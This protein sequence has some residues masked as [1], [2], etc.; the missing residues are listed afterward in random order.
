MYPSSDKYDVVII[1]S[2]LGGLLCGY[3]LSKNGYKVAIFEKN[4][5][6]GGCLQTFKRKGVKF[7]TGMH[8]VG[9]LE[10][11]QMLNKVWKYLNLFDD[12][13]LSKL[14]PT[15]FDVISIAGE[16]YRFASGFENY[17]K[18]L[19]ERFP[20]EK[21]SIEKYVDAIRTI[22]KS[23]PLY[24]LQ[25]P[26][27][28]LY[29][30]SDYFKKSVNEFIGEIVS[31]VELQ[32]VLIGNLPLY[33]GEKNR[34]PIYV[35]ALIQ[36]FYI[37]SSYRIIGGGDAVS[38]S[39]SKSIT[40]MGGQIFANAEVVHIN[41]DEEKAV[42]V[43]LKNGEVVE[44]H[45]FI[46]NIHPQST[47]DKI[48]SKLIRKAYRDRV[49]GLENTVSNFAVYILFKKDTVPY[50]NYNYYHF[51]DT[52]VWKSKEF[53]IDNIEKS[54]FYIH[55]CDEENQ[56]YARAA[57]I[58]CYM[59]YSD[60]AKWAGTKLGNRGKDYEEFKEKIAKR[61]LEKLELAFPNT[62]NNI[63][64]YYTSTPLTYS[65]YTATKE[66]SMYGVLRD[67]NFPSSTMVSQRTKIPNMFLTGQNINSHGVL[68]VT[69]GALI[70]CA[71]FV[72][73]NKIIDDINGAK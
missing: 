29:I 16:R 13:K 54:Y 15:G 10:E 28:N 26:H 59:K 5:Q 27:D 30:E 64:A 47:L 65:D 36:N 1:G 43:T 69:I 71:E 6:I 48:S 12:V 51:D 45:K 7:D 52:D 9:S 11:G 35:H 73:I 57:S 53:N 3:I 60:V 50:N 40:Q 23:S 38:S 19:C 55:Q 25:R 70:T 22:G 4:A 63:E 34:T 49:S 67:V 33:A 58:I 56:K 62:I 42:S 14:D 44:A 72:G 46:S 2:G 8:Y 20:K 24:N 39:L 61:L 66:G 37:Q 18:S 31:N 32:N 17:I 68:G 41:C 21:K